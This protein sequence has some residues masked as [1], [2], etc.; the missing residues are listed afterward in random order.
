MKNDFYCTID[1]LNDSDASIKLTALFAIRPFESPVTKATLSVFQEHYSRALLNGSAH[2]V[3]FNNMSPLS[4]VD[5]ANL[6]VKLANHD[7]SMLKPG[8]QL[9]GVHNDV[10]YLV[11][12][13][14]KNCNIAFRLYL[15]RDMNYPFSTALGTEIAD[16]QDTRIVESHQYADVLLRT[17]RTLE[18]Y[19]RQ[20]SA[21]L[22]NQ[23]RKQA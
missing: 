15:N 17:I 7:F 13:G 14:R 22:A 5:A 6:Y 10:A 4:D 16:L 19:S 23:E 3:R 21:Y 11:I 12:V 8:T 9:W 2:S 1:N 18:A 20:P